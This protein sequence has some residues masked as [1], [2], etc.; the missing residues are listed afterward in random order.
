MFQVPIFMMIFLMGLVVG[1]F[2]N[3][4]IYRL[5]AKESFLRG[6]SFCPRCRHKL[7]WMDLVPVFSFLALRGKCHYCHQKISWQYPLVE[8]ATGSLF[9]LIMNQQL[10]ISG[11]SFLALRSCFL[12]LISCFLIIIFVYDLKHFIIPDKVIYP[13]IAI[14]F[15]YRLLETSKFSLGSFDFTSLLYAFSS[16]ILASSFF[17]LIFLI[18]RGNWLGFGDVKLVFFLGLFLNWPNILVALFSSFLI[19]AVIGTGLIALRRKTLKSEVPFAPFLVIGTFVAL[20][21]GNSIFNWYVSL[22]L[23]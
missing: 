9:V 22:I 8:I 17:L 19:G 14:A 4:V 3:C 2:L 20:F 16:A 1:S 7:S 23:Y 5:D 18:S 12:L 13:A 15:I 11:Q 6:R 21:L 10:V